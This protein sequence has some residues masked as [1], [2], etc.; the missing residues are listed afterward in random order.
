MKISYNWLKAYLPID[1]PPKKVGEILTDTGLEVEGIEK[2]EAIAGGLE[3]LVVGLVLTAQKHPNADKLTLTTVDVGSSEPLQIVCGA[4]NVAEGQ[5]VIVATVGTTLYPKEGEPFVIKKSKIRGETSEGM[6]C[7]EDE[8][9]LGS[10]HDGIMILPP[11]TVVGIPAKEALNLQEDDVFEIGLT[12]NRSDAGCHIGVAKDLAAAL[13]INYGS[14]VKVSLPSVNSFTIDNTDLQIPI[15]V[16]N[17][18]ACPRYAGLTISGVAIKESPDWLKDCLIAI[19][20]R[21]INNVVDATNFVLHELGQPLHAF[22]AD[23]IE[24]GKVVVKNLPSGTKFTTLDEVSRTLHEEDLMICNGQDEGMC[25][26]GVFGGSSTGVTVNTKNIFLESAC[27]S[28]RHIRRTSTRHGLRTDAASRFEKGVDPNQTVYALKRA[29][30]IIKEVAGG[31]ISSDITDLYPTPIEKLKVPLTYGHLKKLL[32]IG[33]PAEQVKAIL[34]ALEMDILEETSEGLLV[35]VPTNKVDVHREADVIEEIVRIFGL[36]NIPFTNSI[37]SAIVYTQKPDVQAVKNAIANLLTGLGFQEILTTSIT[38]VNYYD[39]SDQEGLVRLLSSVNV[40]Y[41]IMRKNMLY[42][43]LEVIAHNQNHKNTDLRLF[44]FGQTYHLQKPTTDEASSVD[45]YT[46]SANLSLFLS[47]VYHLESWRG[48]HREVNFFDAKEI[49]DKIIERLGIQAIQISISQ[50]TDSSLDYTLQYHH[51]KRLLAEIGKVSKPKQRSFDLKSPVYY[52]SLNWDNLIWA[53]QKN[54][55][56]FTPIP[57]YPSVRRDLAMLLDDSI[58]F[59][60]IADIA[61][62]NAGNLLQTVNLFDVYEDETKLGKNKKSYALSFIL[63]DTTKT[64]TDKD[65]ERTMS[66][67]TDACKQQ[68]N[69]ELR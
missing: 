1:L 19:G 33:V 16:E 11:D 65:I 39:E 37:K 62:K 10:S 42:S 30:L 26:A 7:A 57:K 54:K 67:I 69:A 48:K 32:G 50:T 2:I 15:T 41:N 3:G 38:N 56:G 44:E 4:P 64:L 5:K 55:T 20:I 8:I 63:Q 52:A 6:I 27:F 51:R 21:P 13:M 58:T 68:L 25:I 24:G 29:A 12:P 18:D 9:G 61:V 47:G 59:A 28:P 49:A 66:R 31:Q 40:N 60:Q 53:L 23:H 17:Y 36:N 22:D 35:A 45:N 14:T 46:E 43:G 34:H